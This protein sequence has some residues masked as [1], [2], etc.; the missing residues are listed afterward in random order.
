M[1]GEG[2]ADAATDWSIQRKRPAQHTVVGC[3][4]R[5]SCWLSLLQ[6]GTKNT[7][8][9]KLLYSGTTMHDASRFTY[10]PAGW[11]FISGGW[12]LLTCRAVR[13][14]R[15]HLQMSTDQSCGRV[16]V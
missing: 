10:G 13:S 7:S 9:M 12:P 2:L 15:E 5:G 8:E 6:Q 4:V 3:V 1:P 16:S 11:A 14:F